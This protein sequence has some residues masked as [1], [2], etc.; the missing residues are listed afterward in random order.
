MIDISTRM[1]DDKKKYHFN[2][3]IKNLKHEL[4][5]KNQKYRLIP[6]FNFE[7]KFYRNLT[8]DKEFAKSIIFASSD[9][10]INIEN[11]NFYR[12]H[13]LYFLLCLK[14]EIRKSYPF[15]FHLENELKSTPRDLRRVLIKRS[16]DEVSEVIRN[17]CSKAFNYDRFINVN[18]GKENSIKLWNAYNYVNGFS[19]KVCPYCNMELT[20]LVTDCLDEENT[21]YVLRP[22][23]DHFLPKSIFPFYAL[24]INNLIPSCHTCNSSL[25][26]DIDFKRNLHINPMGDSFKNKACFTLSLRDSDLIYDV[27]DDIYNNDLDMN[28]LMIDIKSECDKTK[29]NIKTFELL[30]RYNNH[31]EA[32]SGFVSNLKR[33]SSDSID[34]IMNI[35][36]TDDKNDA[37]NGFL[38]FNPDVTKHCDIPFSVLK[39]DL[40]KKYIKIDF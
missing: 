14:K 30:K 11:Q 9:E 17:R 36:E 16:V 28:K 26:R 18:K 2:G 24:S 32:Y 19:P 37:V 3:F 1:C 22:A 31:K 38:Q 15:N 25:K 12:K 33:I 5:T 27:I 6:E 7:K 29:R 8:I 34:M 21:K 39:N 20:T 10:L 35:Q 23:L 4:Y 13:R 40:I